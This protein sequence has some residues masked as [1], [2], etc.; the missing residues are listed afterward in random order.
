MIH[1]N[2]WRNLFTKSSP[3]ISI[4]LSPFQSTGLPRSNA[5]GFCFQLVPCPLSKSFALFQLPPLTFSS[6]S[7]LGL[8]LLRYSSLFQIKTCFSV[9]E[10]F[11]LGLCPTN[12]NSRNF[13]YQIKSN[14]INTNRIRLHSII[15]SENEVQKLVLPMI[16]RY[17][18]RPSITT[19]III[20]III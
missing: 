1:K 3:V 8:P 18:L 9:A 19:I 13:I 7:F 12:S 2:L 15:N 17:E 11:F 16:I 4:P 10:E 20:I 5:I 14:Q 6:K